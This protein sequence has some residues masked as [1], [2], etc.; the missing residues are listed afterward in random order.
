MDKQPTAAQLLAS[1]AQFLT[2]WLNIIALER[3]LYPAT[4]FEQ[5]NCFNV[6]VPHNRHPGVQ[7]WQQT[8]IQEL[9]SG[10]TLRHLVALRA[11]VQSGD[12]TECYTIDLREFGSIAPDYSDKPI[13]DASFEELVDQFR[14]TLLS[15]QSVI[16]KLSPL[17]TPPQFE[18]TIETKGLRMREEQWVLDNNNVSCINMDNVTAMPVVDCGPIVFY[19]SLEV[20]K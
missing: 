13:V 18:V 19:T 10:L 7:Q 4:A 20:S 17:N 1:L 9:L 6:R 2:S 3:N 5:R 15:F 14:A 16:R 11:V 12:S 8:L